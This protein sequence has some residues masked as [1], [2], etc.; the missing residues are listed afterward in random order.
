MCPIAAESKNPKSR[1][2][3]KINK[4]IDLTSVN[5]M[6]SVKDLATKTNNQ[7]SESE[8]VSLDANEY[9]LTDE[10][11]KNLNNIEDLKS[12]P[13][14]KKFINWIKKRPPEFLSR[15]YKLNKNRN[16]N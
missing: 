9:S 16:H 12:H 2:K 13:K 10:E 4:N 8:K 1:S 14:L 6:E 5:D 11:A 15:T 7:K 3:K